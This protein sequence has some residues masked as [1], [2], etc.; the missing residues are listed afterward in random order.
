M[1][2]HEI[3][4]SDTEMLREIFRIHDEMP[5]AWDPLHRTPEDAVRKL[6]DRVQA[7]SEPQ[8]FWVLP[9]GR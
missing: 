6:V 5:V 3:A 7:S 8:G 4:P 1:W 2:L 9:L